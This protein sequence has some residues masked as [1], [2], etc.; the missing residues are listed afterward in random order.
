MLASHMAIL[1]IG[2]AVG[3][4]LAPSLFTQTILPGITANAIAAVLFNLLAL[5]ALTRVKIKSS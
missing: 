1:A 2:R 4:L 5:V 3:D